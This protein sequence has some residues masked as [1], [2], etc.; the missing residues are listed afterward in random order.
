VIYTALVTLPSALFEFDSDVLVPGATLAAA[1]VFVPVRRRV[2]AVV[3]R[4]FNRIH[5]DARRIV[6]R[7]GARLQH[8]QGIDVMA[9]DLQA[10]VAAKV[11]PAHVA[12]WI[13][14][15]LELR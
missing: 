11:Q 4:R 5:Y 9:G 13:R 12:L 6:E 1:A 15:Q 7:F 3:D 2:Q 8:D 14:R 10:A